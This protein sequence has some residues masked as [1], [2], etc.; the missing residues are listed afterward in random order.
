MIFRRMGWAI[1]VAF[2]GAVAT[3][4]AVGA[5]DPA[6]APSW[7]FNARQQQQPAT[8]GLTGG[9]S[10]ES[11]AF[12]GTCGKEIVVAVDF[13]RSAIAEL[14]RSDAYPWVNFSV[15]GERQKFPIDLL[16]LNEAGP[17]LWTPEISR[18]PKEFFER[19]AVARTV[20]IQLLGEDKILDEYKLEKNSG[21]KD[22]MLRVAKECF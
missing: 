1:R 20:S 9:P 17:N 7:F 13:K 22:S 19:L 3:A 4:L 18:L 21:R 6:E 11:I 10:S 8:F 5:A 2:A 14:V 16:R 15:D 12:F